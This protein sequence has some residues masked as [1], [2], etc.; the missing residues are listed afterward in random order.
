MELYLQTGYGMMEHCSALISKWTKG[1]VIFSPKDMTI[2][3]MSDSSKKIRKA[4]GTI[5]I[6]PQFY[7]PRAEISNLIAHPFWPRQYD[8][9]SFYTSA[10]AKELIDNL[11]SLYI[12]PMRANAFIIPSLLLEDINDNWERITNLIITE[13]SKR[14][15]NIPK[16]YTLCVSDNVFK[17]EEKTHE[18]LDFIE[19]LPV[20]GFYIIPIHPENRYLV[21]DVSWLINVM[22]FC[23]GIKIRGKKVIL[24]YSNH[25]FLMMSLCKVDAICAGTWLKTRTFPIGDFNN[26][27]DQEGGRKTVWYYCP[28]SLTEYQI[29]FLDIAARVGVL[30]NLKTPSNFNSTYTDILFTGAQPSLVRFS[31]REAFRHYLHCLRIQ[32]EEVTKPTFDETIKYLRILFQ[33]A[34]DLTTFFRSQGIRGK[35][36]DFFN[37]AEINISI[38]DSFESIRG[39]IFSNKWQ[40]I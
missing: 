31:E 23:A 36:R 35:H 14:K 33:T 5:M 38:L 40:S 22:D 30:Q 16:Y 27:N 1:T 4:G 12:E 18:L 24:G 19:N 8:T 7:V 20:D 10:G 6:D 11:L 32:C 17:D 3:Q 28:Q 25:Q 29:Q 39:L 13:I 37:I 26:S 34:L 15:I 21:D 9:G 2:D